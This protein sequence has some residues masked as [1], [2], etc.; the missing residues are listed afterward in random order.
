MSTVRVDPLT[1]NIEISGELMHRFCA[2]CRSASTQPSFVVMQL[3]EHF[4]EG[5]ETKQ[6]ARDGQLDYREFSLRRSQEL[7]D[8][9][10]HRIDYDNVPSGGPNSLYQQELRLEKEIEKIIEDEWKRIEQQ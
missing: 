5:E 9:M 6:E 3:I 2:A 1:M 10:K 7:W 4:I 8:Q